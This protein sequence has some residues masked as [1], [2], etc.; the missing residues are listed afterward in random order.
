MSES[1]NKLKA[2]P[3]DVGLMLRA[4]AELRC[5][6]R[7]VIPVLREV[8]TRDE[9]PEEQLGAAM[10]YLEVIWIEARRRAAET[11]CAHRGLAVP[12][13]PSFAEERAGSQSELHD[14]ACRYYDA[15]KA[16]REAVSR[17]IALALETCERV[18]FLAP[19]ADP[20]SSV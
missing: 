12:S 15:V 13:P 19:E 17:R 8:E 11:D 3:A 9:L 5:L 6:S 4:H 7:E 18:R 16:L 1:I 20:L 14:R 2:P 10:A